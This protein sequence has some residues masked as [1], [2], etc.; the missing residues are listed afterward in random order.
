MANRNRNVTRTDSKRNRRGKG[1]RSRG[2]RSWTDKE[3]K[4]DGDSAKLNAEGRDNNPNWYFLDAKVA[5]QVSQLSFQQLAGISIPIDGIDIA[6][7]NI[8][9]VYLNPAPGVQKDALY[10]TGQVQKSA[11][12]MA[13]F[14]LFSKLSAYTGRI[15]AYGPQDISTMILAMGE[16]ISMVEFIRRSFGVAFTMNMRNRAYPKAILSAMTIDPDDLMAH[17]S[18][19]RTE[20]NS[21]ITRINQLPIPRNVAYFEKCA[22]LYEKIYVDMPSSMGQT[23]FYVPSTTWILDE[24]SYSGGTILRTIDVAQDHATNNPLPWANTMGTVL[25]TLNNMVDA[26]LSSS[27]LQIVYTD[28]L[29]LATKMETPFWKFDYLM[30]GYTVLPEYNT[31]F[32]LQF[33][34]LTITGVPWVEPSNANIAMGVTP[35]ND[36]YPDANNNML[37][38]NPAFIGGV[39][40]NSAYPRMG[41]EAI[42][43]MLSDTPSV[44]DRIEVTRFMSLSDSTFYIPTTQSTSCAVINT[45]LPDHYVTGIGFRRTDGTSAVISATNLLSSWFYSVG[46]PLIQELSIIDW[47]PRFYGTDT[48]GTALEPETMVGDLN[49]YTTIDYQFLAKLH[50]FVGLALYDVR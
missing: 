41:T 22:S 32:L 47:S 13:G 30:E 3:K 46:N 23:I 19:Y 4:Y 36:V 12:N 21:I 29:N 14:R 24:T 15:A 35:Y 2:N 18:D 45:A 16:I 43:D 40:V 37:F 20:F 48:S 44:E 34:N 39:V 7:P 9:V 27:T 28:L 17:F 25:L 6:V 5:E 33:H 38:Y 26:L 31:N 8:S 11:I 1:E 42:V 10:S 49:F 50:D